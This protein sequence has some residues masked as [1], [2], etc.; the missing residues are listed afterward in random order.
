MK[1][2]EST[3]IDIIANELRLKTSEVTLESEFVNDLGV[4][5]LDYV[6]LLVTLEDE[7]KIVFDEDSHKDVTTVKM[8]VEAIKLKL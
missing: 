2:I 6:N 4:D 1:D 7:F 8:L 5:S 3:V